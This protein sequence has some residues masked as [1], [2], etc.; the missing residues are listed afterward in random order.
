MVKPIRFRD[1]R[2]RLLDHD[3]RFSFRPGKGSEVILS[4]PAI[5][6]ACCIPRH[7]DGH[8]VRPPVLQKVA[9]KFALPPGFFDPAHRRKP[10]SARPTPSR[11]SVFRAVYETPSVP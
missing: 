9:R 8:T 2:R 4:H 11:V 3:P 7:G 5:R 10:P 1:L 6:A